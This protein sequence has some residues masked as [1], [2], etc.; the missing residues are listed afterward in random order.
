MFSTIVLLITVTMFANVF[1]QNTA[2]VN[3]DLLNK[4]TKRALWVWKPLTS[5]QWDG[6]AGYKQ[7]VDNHKKSQ[8]NLIDFCRNKSINTIYVYVGAWEWDQS[9]FTTGKLYNEAGYASL[10]QKANA[11]GIKVWA[12][13]Y[14]YDDPNN[15]TDY[16]NATQKIIDAVGGFNQRHPTIGFEGVQSDNEPSNA[17]VY[18]NMID[19]CKIAQ[20]KTNSWKTTLKNAGAK[21]FIFSTVLKPSWVFETYTYNGVNKEM[22]KFLVDNSDHV[23]LMD[24]FDTQLKL[25]EKALPVLAYAA[26]LNPIKPVAIGIE[27][28]WVSV[29]APNTYDDDIKA[30]SVTTR[31]NKME[32]DLDA[33]EAVFNTYKS[34][35]RIAIHD[36]PQYYFHWF[37]KEQGYWLD[38][39]T[40]WNTPPY[41][42]LNSDAS[43]FANWPNSLQVTN[44]PPVITSTPA[45]TA[46]QNS[47][48][49][50]TIAATDANNDLLTYSATL[51]PTWL[52]FNTSTRVLSGTPSAANV[53]NHNVTLRVTDGKVTTDQAFVITVAATTSVVNY[54]LNPG[55]ESTG[56]WNLWAATTTATCTKTGTKGAQ[57]SANEA[58]F[59]QIINGLK[60]STT[61]R[62]KGYVNTKGSTVSLGV[63]NY[64]GKTINTKCISAT[65]TQF[66]ATFTTGSSNTS[67]T[68]YLYRKGN[69]SLVCADDFEVIENLSSA[70]IEEI[71]TQSSMGELK[72]Y[73]NPASSN[74]QVEYVLNEP[75]TIMIDL[76]NIQGK[77]VNTIL[78]PAVLQAGSYSQQIDTQQLEKGIYY[79]RYSSNNQVQN[80]QLS[81]L[82]H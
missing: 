41:T 60:P 71:N 43:Q 2:H 14:F 12:L 44:A 11:V 5:P 81:V 46:T 31:F 47:T 62:F 52:I 59:E 79:L 28:G 70:R 6:V 69:T 74:A 64:G 29:T 38:V 61:Y 72:V 18:G 51:L 35:E 42:N 27:T 63:K 75:S 8:D 30:E 68:V 26:S 7:L 53:G 9:T 16:A 19:F 36:L 22:F 17:A 15:F 58:G 21:P 80:M 37:G 20:S 13:F 48:Y 82:P 10:I 49:T 66:T 24:Y 57:L 73:P 65:M 78:A 1:A 4:P 23:A 76:Y 32:T 40:T 50:Y 67:A 54:V 3:W 55:F 34:Y 25:K 33:V 56:S 45:L 77:L 39:N